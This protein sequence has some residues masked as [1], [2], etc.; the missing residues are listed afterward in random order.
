MKRLDELG[1]SRTPWTAYTNEDFDSSDEVRDENDELILCDAPHANARLIAAAPDLYE[2]LRVCET[3]MCDYCRREAA[4]TMQG[5]PCENGCAVMLAA[6]AAL[7][8]A[9]GRGMTRIIRT[10]GGRFAVEWRSDA[11]PYGW[12]RVATPAAPNIDFATEA[13]AEDFAAKWEDG[14]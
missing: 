3:V 8:K 1:V 4:H 13:E 10:D 6:K 14:E 9:G 2:A 11:R 12:I 5:F 7:E